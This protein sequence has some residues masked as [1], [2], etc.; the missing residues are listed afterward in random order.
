MLKNKVECKSAYLKVTS[1][2]RGISDITDVLREHSNV[3]HQANMSEA[4]DP[5]QFGFFAEQLRTATCV[6]LKFD[7]YSADLGVEREATAYAT[8]GQALSAAIQHLRSEGY[9][10]KPF[11]LQGM[12]DKV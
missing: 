8:K 3:V 12:I 7:A 5:R 4:P 6:V 11:D 10:A 9:E 1:K 2:Q